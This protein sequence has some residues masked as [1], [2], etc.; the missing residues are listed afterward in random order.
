[1]KKPKITKLDYLV[2]FLIIVAIV[3]IIYFGSIGVKCKLL[4]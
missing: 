2:I 3:F 4:E 1:M